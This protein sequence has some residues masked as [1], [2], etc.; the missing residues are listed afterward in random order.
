MKKIF[1]K[2][3]SCDDKNWEIKKIK[4]KTVYLLAMIRTNNLLIVNPIL[5]HIANKKQLE[6]V[7]F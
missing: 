1:L 5:Y 4:N 6:M 3:R 7:I 2:M